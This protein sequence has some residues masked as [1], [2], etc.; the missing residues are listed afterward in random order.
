[1]PAPAGTLLI[2]FSTVVNGKVHASN[3]QLENVIS[4]GFFRNNADLPAD[5]L[6]IC[7]KAGACNATRAAQRG[8]PFSMVQRDTDLNR[9]TAGTSLSVGEPPDAYGMKHSCATNRP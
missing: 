6:K 3:I 4:A 8:D 9:F 5:V 2:P 7:E 1:L